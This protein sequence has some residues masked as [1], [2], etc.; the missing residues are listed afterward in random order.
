MRKRNRNILKSKREGK[1][2][3]ITNNNKNLNRF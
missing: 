1:Y 3:R 2:N